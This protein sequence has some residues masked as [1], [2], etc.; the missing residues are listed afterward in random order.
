MEGEEFLDEFKILV[1][2]E[3]LCTMKLFCYLKINYCAIHYIVPGIHPTQ[4]ANLIL[5]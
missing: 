3:G 2:Q 1:S 5:F 4:Y